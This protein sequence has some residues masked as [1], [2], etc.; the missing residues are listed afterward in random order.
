MNNFPFLANG[1]ALTLEQARADEN[2]DLDHQLDRFLEDEKRDEGEFLDHFDQND[3]Q[4][5]CQAIQLQVCSGK[6]F[7][8]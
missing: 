2:E 1:F 3:N 6:R 5:V 4:A 7:A 8:L